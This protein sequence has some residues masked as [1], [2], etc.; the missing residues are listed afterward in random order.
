MSQSGNKNKSGL[1]KVNNKLASNTSLNAA[2]TESKNALAIDNIIWKY[3]G[4]LSQ[5]FYKKRINDTLWKRA[6][7]FKDVNFVYP[8][9]NTLQ[10]LWDSV[11][12]KEKPTVK[13]IAEQVKTIIQAIEPWTDSQLAKD[14]LSIYVNLSRTSPEIFGDLL[15]EKGALVKTELTIFW[16]AAVQVLGKNFELEKDI[17]VPIA[18][19]SKRKRKIK[20]KNLLGIFPSTVFRRRQLTLP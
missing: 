5:T 3:A 7:K 6:V 13:Q 17:Y 1:N 2:A 14:S 18:K 16:A 20:A 15:T 11:N 12:K 9:V 8:A 19:N 4:F 10:K